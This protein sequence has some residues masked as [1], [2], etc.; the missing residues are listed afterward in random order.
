MI[1]QESICM[2]KKLLDI[3]NIFIKQLHTL[4]IFSF[5]FAELNKAW[6]CDKR[7]GL[8]A[9]QRFIFI[10]RRALDYLEIKAWIDILGNAPY[11]KLQTSQFAGSV[12]VMSPK[13]GKPCGDLC[14]GGRFCEDIAE[15]LP[16]VDEYLRP[17]YNELLPCLSSSAFEQP[18]YL[19][20]CKFIDKWVDV[21][22]TCWCKFEVLNKIE[23]KP[24]NGT[25]W[26]EYA[27]SSCDPNKIFDYSNRTSKQ[28]STHKEFCQLISVLKM[29]FNELKGSHTP[30]CTKFAYSN[31]IERLQTKYRD[32]TGANIEKF[33]E[34][35]FEPIAIKEAK[36]IAN[37][38]ITNKRCNNKAWRIDYSELFERYVQYVFGE[39]AK[40]RNA[41]SVCNPHFQI[42][43][44]SPFWVP[45]Y[46]EP[47]LVLVSGNTQYVI[48]AK[49]K[50][51]MFNK[52]SC[53]TEL[54]DIFRH[55]LHQILA[56]CSL[57]NMPT[58]K[59]VLVYPFNDF[60]F[61]QLTIKSHLTSSISDVYLVGIPFKK[62][63]IEM[64]KTQ[65]T[66]N[67]IKF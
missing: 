34:Y 48:D 47:D 63:K 28:T 2:S 13:N 67:I 25:R 50:S 20:C 6:G 49:Y 31:K 16:M 30:M 54:K 56:Y 18:I 55:D 19:E 21:E 46:L 5:S 53:S 37:V 39:V 10:N 14:I 32:V 36:R 44:Q 51:H 27:L 29:C 7:Y 40:M 8:N 38:I 41:K 52:N 58:K 22:K 11:L 15:L 66:E 12:P 9:L 1:I 65:L 42:Y 3:S 43:G 59:A 61:R 64:L 26:E 35:P 17:E 57:N 4:G 23:N 45:R 24:S 60:C 62:G 33:I